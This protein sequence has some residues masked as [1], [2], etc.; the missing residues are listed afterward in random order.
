VAGE[1]T[2]K[3]LEVEEP[4]QEIVQEQPK[5]DPKPVAPPPVATAAPEAPQFVPATADQVLKDAPLPMLGAPL[6]EILTAATPAAA[7]VAEIAKPIVQET[8]KP[9]AEIKPEPPKP[10]EPA[11]VE[12]APVEQKR[13]EPPKPIEKQPEL[14][15]PDPKP[16]IEAEKPK[17][18][19]VKKTTA[20]KEQKKRKGQNASQDFNAD[21]GRVDAKTKGKSTKDAS[22]GSSNREVGNAAADNYKG[23]VEKKL[24]R[25]QKRVRHRGEG[26]LV[27][28]FTITADGGVTGARVSRSSGDAKLDQ[29]GLNILAKASPFPPIPAEAGRKSWKMTVPVDFR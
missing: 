23:L 27:L 20:K 25:A 19:T 29:A 24:S 22:R 14:R 10:A 1:E 21:R 9:I 11:K 5:P 6:P 16:V 13:L 12:A 8:P 18:K 26:R 28:S 3:D 2:A 4:R 15:K 7:K 17:A